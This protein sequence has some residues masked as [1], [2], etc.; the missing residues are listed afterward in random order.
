MCFWIQNVKTRIRSW[1]KSN[2][3]DT[4]HKIAFQKNNRYFILILIKVQIRIAL[5]SN[6]STN[7]G[8]IQP[9]CKNILKSVRSYL[10]FEKTQIK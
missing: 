3:H 10:C 8:F 6:I 1:K 9:S 4:K 5:Y 7:I 2:K